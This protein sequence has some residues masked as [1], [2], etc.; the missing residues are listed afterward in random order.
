MVLF[1]N[2]YVNVEKLFISNS[3]K[4]VQI[5]NSNNNLYITSL[6][7]RR[8]D[9]AVD[10]VFKN[11][12]SMDTIKSKSSLMARQLNEENKKLQLSII[13]FL[14]CQLNSKI[15]DYAFTR[16]INKIDILNNAVKVRLKIPET[17]ITTD[18]AVLK[19]FFSKHGG[20]IITKPISEALILS[21]D[22]YNYYTYT[23][24]IDDITDFP[25]EW[26]NL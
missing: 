25:M 15:E 5:S 10:S 24:Q 4:V 22:E 8:G 17:I 9:I 7:Y 13:N 21:D 16:N 26:D 1:P 3:N 23:S 2:E 19:D 11:S 14:A 18:K 12:I 20:K 6:W